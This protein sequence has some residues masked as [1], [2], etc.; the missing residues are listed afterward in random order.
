[1]KIYT[2]MYESD[3]LCFIDGRRVTQE[4]VKNFPT[5]EIQSV[6]VLSRGS[7]AALEWG[8]EGKT[9]DIIL[10]KTKVLH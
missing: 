6:T 8:E 2:T 3:I 10:M 5:S 4:E 9:H 1:M 7:K